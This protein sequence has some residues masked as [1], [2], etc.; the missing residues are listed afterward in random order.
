[1]GYRKA[2]EFLLKDYLIGVHPAKSE[3]IKKSFLGTCIRDYVANSNIKA[4]SKRAVWLGNDETHYVRIWEGKD[5]E[6]LKTLV[7]LTVRWI[8]MEQMTASVIEEMPDTTSVAPSA[9][10]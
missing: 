5:L 10:M 7:D 9:R 3:E 2:L 4:V 6:D 8:E 1:M